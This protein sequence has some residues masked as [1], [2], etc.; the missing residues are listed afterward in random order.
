MHFIALPPK[1]TAPRHDASSNTA[2]LE[3]ERLK[4]ACAWSPVHTVLKRK[5]LAAVTRYT[6]EDGSILSVYTNGDASWR[7]RDSGEQ[8][9]PNWHTCNAQGK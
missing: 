1:K 5:R 7:F 2:T 4:N 8:R 3:M 6:F 9:W